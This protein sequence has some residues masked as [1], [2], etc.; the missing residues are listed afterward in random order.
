MLRQ[1]QPWQRNAQQKYKS[2]TDN[3]RSSPSSV[4]YGKGADKLAAK[5][6][7]GEWQLLIA[8]LVLSH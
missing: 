2:T 6:S 3:K 1:K 5:S 8:I 4:E 7:P